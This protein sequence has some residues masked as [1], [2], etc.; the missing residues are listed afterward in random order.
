[1]TNLNPKHINKEFVFKSHW[2]VSCCGTLHF[3]VLF[4]Q[5]KG[6]RNKAPQGKK[7]HKIFANIEKKIGNLVPKQ[8]IK[9][10]KFF[11]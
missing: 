2:K 7:K 11:G 9:K 10:I 1:M 5:K 8:S 4:R 6:L 3:Y